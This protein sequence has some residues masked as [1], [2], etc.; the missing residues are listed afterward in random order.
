MSR[1]KISIL[2]V[3][4]GDFIYAVSPL[5]NNMV[6]D[7]GSGDIIPSSFLATIQ[8]ID[9]LQITHPHT[10]HFDDIIKISKKNIRSFRCPSLDNFTDLNIGKNKYDREKIN[11]LRE[12][13]RTI[14]K[15]D[16]AVVSGSTFSRGVYFPSVVDYTD[17][18]TASC[19][20]ILS[21][22]GFKI[23]FGGDLPNEG[24]V[25]L[26]KQE[27]F[28]RAINGINVFK[29]PHHGREEGCSDALFKY[30]SPQL[31]IISDK[32]IDKTNKNTV[33]TDWYTNR[34]TGANVVKSDGGVD[35]RKVV[36]TRN[37]GSIFI[38]VAEDGRWTVYLNTTWL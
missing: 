37:D 24:W 32:P 26:L 14:S 23:L 27:N 21:Y 4:H 29:V 10:D 31:C 9:E 17:P 28:R 8:T 38:D 25:N 3:G 20:T 7:C 5:G 19:V 11:K 6:I 18:N 22:A 33:V 35:T 36:S 15:N 34:S 2:D 1:L 16:D 12:L 30:I 13:K